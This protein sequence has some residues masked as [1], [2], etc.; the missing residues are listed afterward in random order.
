MPERT[1]PVAGKPRLLR[2]GGNY[3]SVLATL[4]PGLI[5][6]VPIAEHPSVRSRRLTR[7]RYMVASAAGLAAAAVL[8]AMIGWWVFPPG[9]TRFRT[10][11]K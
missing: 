7:I 3:A 2:I 5:Q 4:A 1:A 11:R 6:S 10:G 9:G 8:F